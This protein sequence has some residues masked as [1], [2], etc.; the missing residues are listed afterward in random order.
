PSGDRSLAHNI[1]V[2]AVQYQMRTL[3]S[4][5]EFRSQCEFYLDTAA[6]YRCDFVV[7]PELLT[8]QLQSLTRD[9]RPGLSARRL[10]EYTERYL[11]FFSEAAIRYYVNIIGGTHLIVENDILYNAAYLFRRDGSI[12]RQLKIHITPSEQRWWGV[13]P[14]SE[15]KVFET[16]RGPIAILIC[17]DV[18]FPELGRIAADKGAGVFFVPYNTD[19]RQAHMRV[20]S[21]AHARCIENHVYVVTAG[22]VGNL[23]FVEGADIHYAESAVLTPCDIPFPRDGVATQATPNV[24]AMLIHDLDMT[25]LR[26]NRRIGIVRPWFDRRTDV[27]KV[28]YRDGDD[29]RQV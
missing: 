9:E 8:T 1:R 17:Y 2:A 28:H 29:D 11:Q 24:E 13:S 22:A 19:I 23:P 14:G 12:D 4:F 6:E 20:R 18:E 10:D 21:C 16:D 27:Y 15:M 26:R 3:H 5:D 7:Y 25:T